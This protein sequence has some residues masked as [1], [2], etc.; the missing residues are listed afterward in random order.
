MIPFQIAVG[1]FSGVGGWDE[2]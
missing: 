2:E 1:G